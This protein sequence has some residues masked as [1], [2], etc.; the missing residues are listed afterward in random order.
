[1]SEQLKSKALEAN[2]AQTRIDTIKLPQAQEEF[3]SLS[4]NHFG[5]HKRASD[6][7][8]EFNHPYAN[9]PFLAEEYRKI[10]LSDF[11]FY[12]Q[13]G[14]LPIV[15]L[16]EIARNYINGDYSDEVKTI[17]L[18][19]VLEFLGQ[20][21]PDK[22]FI[23]TYAALIEIII[24]GFENNQL[25]YAANSNYLKKNMAIVSKEQIASD[26][27]LK[28]L[29]KYSHYSIELWKSTSDFESWYDEK[30]HIFNNDYSTYIYSI[31]KEYFDHI[32]ELVNRSENAQDILKEN[33]FYSDIAKHFRQ[34]S[35]GFER[36]IEKLYYTIYLIHLPCMTHLKDHLL[37][38]INSTLREICN[39]LEINDLKFFIEN[40]FQLFK[41]F[42]Q[43]HMNIVLDCIQTLGREIIKTK[44][45]ILISI[46]ENQ[47]ISFGFVTPGNVYMKGNWQWHTDT[48]HLKNLRIWLEFI[49]SC[50]LS[51]RKLLSALI[52]YLKTGGIFIFDTDLFQ[53]D[54]S[55]LL[56]SNIVTIY[57]Q[58]KQL[59]R[60]FPVY[61]NEIGAEG[62]LRDVTTHLDEISH[63]QDKLI[64]FLR[65]QIHIESNNAHIGLIGAI[66]QFWLTLKKDI[67]IKFIPEDV[68]LSIDINNNWYKE[69]HLI[70]KELCKRHKISDA[71][72]LLHIEK[73]NFE[74]ISDALKGYDSKQIAR[75]K[76]LHHLNILIK[77]KYSFEAIDIGKILHKHNFIKSTTVNKLEKYIK[78]GSHINAIKQVYELMLQ[79][80]NIIFDPEPSE[81]WE[82]IYHKRHIAFGIPSMYGDYHEKKFEALGLTFRLEF[83]ASRLMEKH[84]NALKTD[85]ITGKQ[86]SKIYYIFELLYEGLKLDGIT[87]QGFES[88]LMM[89][90]YSLVSKSFTLE[91]YINLLQ[92]LEENIKEIINKYFIRPYD[93]LLKTCLNNLN[94][95]SIN[96]EKKNLVYRHKEAE[97]F[98]RNMLSSAFLIQLLDNFIARVIY[99]MQNMVDRLSKEDI[100]NIMTYN[101]DLIISP[102]YKKTK[103]MDNSV[104]LGSK[105]YFLK[106]MYLSGLPVPPGF[107]ITTEVF[108]RK[109]SILNH[110]NL[111]EEIDNLIKKNVQ[112]LEKMT[113]DLFGNPERP[114]LLSVRSGTAFS[115]PGAMNTFLNVGMNDQIVEVFS[116]KKD[117]GWTSW[118]CYRRLL[119]SWAM[120]Y[121]IE[122]DVF[123]NVMLSFKQKYK[124]EQKINFNN[125]QMKE[126]AL[127]Y[128]QVLQ[129][130][131]IVFPED[132]FEQLKQAILH[133]F[134]SWDSPRAKVYR[135]HLH[136]A[137]EWGTAV[138][139]QKMVLG[140]IS[141]ESGTG[142]VFT[143]NTNNPKPGIH[144]NGDFVFCSQGEDVVAGLVKVFPIS[145]TQIKENESKF[146]LENNFPQLFNKI[147]S[148]S[149]D[150]LEKLKL[151]HQ[152]IEFTFESPHPKDFH[153][154]QT[155]DQYI[156]K[157]EKVSVFSTSQKRMKLL[158][159]GTGIGNGVLNGRIAFDLD[160][161]MQ[162][163]KQDP[164][165]NRILVRPDT[166]PDDIA[167]I[168]ECEGLITGR[169]GITS[170][171]AVTASR[172]E[173]ICVVNCSEI[174]VDEINKKL[175]INNQVLN[176]FDLI[177]IDGNVGNIYLGNYKTVFKDFES[178]NELN[179]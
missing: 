170:H 35:M 64:H 143:H 93:P 5:I 98:Y 19:S 167:L 78:S 163:K 141:D 161:L 85:Y 62:E 115:M 173:K 176:S 94:K 51:F 120:A 22:L 81:G 4:Q 46:F 118:D 55:K 174:V 119:Q 122:R 6:F 148:I 146:S 86:L 61:F 72:E 116:K 37:W 134:E 16:T 41:E 171:A 164:D 159:R 160:D 73:S 76:M 165:G 92:F 75:V 121:G 87:N 108:R 126:M 30:K 157:K 109:Q 132:P 15:V 34:S 95:D 54:I 44:N 124:V 113:G 139:I 69:P 68:L 8:Y 177:A 135:E 80:N 79:L 13:K 144:L 7:F 106:K 20:N 154:L 3:L 172:L 150:L 53:R 114:L 25:L 131:N 149:V 155:R 50:P 74:N 103:R 142:V 32:T 47:L 82:N 104:F 138:I 99:S 179:P 48:N 58:I 151:N 66:F 17:I 123:D 38:E 23:D 88:N 130:N 152:E 11:W 2:L 57:K 175:F 105:A 49:G 36:S 169:G 112:H 102:L 89:F 111:N 117:F 43:K 21:I 40:I 125:A 128:K 168:F 31:S 84:I 56:N 107:V 145:S 153:I 91:Q 67:L 28:F 27:L 14:T 24:E 33:V 9:H 101:P 29:K 90:K 10:F 39:E 137:Q 100:T 70:V 127:A 52:I 178:A 45:E 83:L 1:M 136:I 97:T 162:L 110:P 12:A 158:T 71:E 59:A 26:A 60:I 77:E 65:K 156:K 133:V 18:Q 63:R 42:S 147:F 140:N 96:D 129:K 166:V